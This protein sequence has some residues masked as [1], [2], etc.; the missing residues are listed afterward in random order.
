MYY[1]YI[2]F[3]FLLF[4]AFSHHLFLQDTKKAN[5]LTA[6]LIQQRQEVLFYIICWALVLG[7]GCLSWTFLQ[8]ILLLLGVFSSLRMRY[9]SQKSTTSILPS[10]SN[11]SNNVSLNQ[12]KSTITIKKPIHHLTKGG[13]TGS[14]SFN[15]FP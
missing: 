13:G 5:A 12:N 10:S 15:F 14:I 9:S 1:W 8:L 11:T 3:L 7:W 6:M 2:H 4:F